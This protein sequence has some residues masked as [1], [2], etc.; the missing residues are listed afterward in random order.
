M[1]DGAQQVAS[2]LDRRRQDRRRLAHQ[3]HVVGPG[4]PRQAVRR[5]GPRYQQPQHPLRPVA[6]APRAGARRAEPP[7]PARRV[8]AHRSRAPRRP[9]AAAA[10]HDGVSRGRSRS[11][12]SRSGPRPTGRRRS[13]APTRAACSP[14]TPATASATTSSVALTERLMA[15]YVHELDGT[16]SAGRAADDRQAEV[17]RLHAGADA[18]RREGAAAGRLLRPADVRR[19]AA[20]IP[21][22]NQSVQ[23]AVGD[24]ADRDRPLAGSLTISGTDPRT[25][26]PVAPLSLNPADDAAPPPRTAPTTT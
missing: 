2:N 19:S 3:R 4:C 9:R 18:V 12:T 6:P 26:L 5:R 20:P 10:L 11:P 7:R 16:V 1:T 21:A 23:A 13:P 14:A 8:G 22:T 24:G 15:L 25:H 17:P